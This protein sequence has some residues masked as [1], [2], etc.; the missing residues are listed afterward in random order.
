MLQ[1]EEVIDSNSNVSDDQD[2]GMEA[3]MDAMKDNDPMKRMFGMGRLKRAL[4]NYCDDK[5]P[6]SSF[7]K[8]LFKGFYTKDKWELVNESE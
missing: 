6:L 3:A 8:N 4:Q 7:D 2:F 5:T 1:R